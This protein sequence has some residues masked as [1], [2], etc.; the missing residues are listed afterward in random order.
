MKIINKIAR[1]NNKQIKIMKF[2]NNKK[3]KQ[4]IIKMY[5]KAIKK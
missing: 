3:N 2:I 5:K 4:H 1:K